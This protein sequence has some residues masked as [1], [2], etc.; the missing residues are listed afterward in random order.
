MITK[1]RTAFST[2]QLLKSIWL[3]L[4]GRLIAHISTFAA[5]GYHNVLMMK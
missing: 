2:V 4:G 5:V 1:S 3:P